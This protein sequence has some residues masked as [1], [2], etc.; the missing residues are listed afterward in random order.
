[1]D[2]KGKFFSALAAKVACGCTLKQA[3]D[4]VGCS[5]SRAYRLNLQPAFRSKVNELRTAA[6]AESIGLLATASRTAVQRLIELTGNEDA[7]VALRACTA[8]LDRFTSLSEHVDLRS[9][10]EALEIERQTT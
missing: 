5:H 10:V 3:A 9:R 1:M 6:V 2:A 7:S 4:E 8:I